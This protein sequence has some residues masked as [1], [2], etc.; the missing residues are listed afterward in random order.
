[1]NLR[2]ELGAGRCPLAA[3]GLVERGMAIGL[4]KRAAH[5]RTGRAGPQDLDRHVGAR[6]RESRIMLG[7]SQQRLA[8]LIGVTYQQAHKYERGINRISAG[9]LFNVAQ[10]SGIEVGQL[11]EGWG[12]EGSVKPMPQKRMLLELTRNYVTMSEEH[13]EAICNLARALA[14]EA[15]PAE[16][17]PE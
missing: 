8:D 1:M 4:M 16:G 2:V 9:M 5:P 6:I 12:S 11:F 15:A 13:R 14:V 10:T 3:V 7:L 17:H